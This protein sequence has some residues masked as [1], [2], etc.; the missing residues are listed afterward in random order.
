M[1]WREVG[2]GILIVAWFAALSAG[3]P[4]PAVAECKRDPT[5]YSLGSK[6]VFV[7][8]DP[9]DLRCY[10]C[11]NRLSDEHYAS[12]VFQ[13]LVKPE[14][15]TR[16]PMPALA[17]SWSVSADGLSLTFTLRPNLKWDSGDPITT[18]DV[19]ATFDHLQSETSCVRQAYREFASRIV[20]IEELNRNV[21]FTF[22]DRTD[23]VVQ[24]FYAYP[25]L[26]SALLRATGLGAGSAVCTGESGVNIGAGPYLLSSFKGLDPIF[27]ANPFFQ[28]GNCRPY[29]NQLRM[30]VVGDR[31]SWPSLLETGAVDLL[32]DV[33]VRYT[34]RYLNDK[35]FK[36]KVYGF[37]SCV[38]VA[39]NFENPLFRDDRIRRAMTHAYDRRRI[40][41]STFSGRGE[42]LASPLGTSS[43]YYNRDVQ[44][45]EYSPEQ[46]M[47]F[48]SAVGLHDE[49]GDNRLE[50]NGKDIR[51][52]L[53]VP[54]SLYVEYEPAVEFFRSAMG[55]VGIEIETRLI[56]DN[57]LADLKER[58]R[59]WDLLW[60]RWEFTD[61]ISVFRA[62]ETN[63]EDNFT[64]FTDERLDSFLARARTTD[65]VLAYSQF[66]RSAQETLNQE[67]PF[68]FLWS[69]DHVAVHSSRVKGLRVSAY[70][71][72]DYIDEAWVEN[73]R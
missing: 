57:R 33:P 53:V 3:Q 43:R 30:H 25:I 18:V 35:N 9:V 12:L 67:C 66:L 60:G 36:T 5:R 6:L 20:S 29:I 64:G 54:Q 24:N 34:L 68:I 10:Y 65:D 44:P 21:T 7:E 69:L 42:V 38:F 55:N 51:L 19:L 39:F 26:P 31:S 61:G 22:R 48:F 17:E 15:D 62:F 11:S 40:L 2:R 8:R 14:P 4:G 16:E 27:D 58:D 13:P 1:S 46:A 45:L 63:H 59:D 52:R 41:G 70:N 23:A 49:N 47:A 73:P 56:E 72:F 71:F 37:L 28:G 32:I 50:F